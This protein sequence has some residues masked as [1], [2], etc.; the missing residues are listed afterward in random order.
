VGMAKVEFSVNGS[1]A[2]TDTTSP[3]TCSWKVTGRRGA[4]YTLVARAYDAAG[5]TADSSVHVTSQ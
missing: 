2:C 5:N 4:A 3:Y 1:L